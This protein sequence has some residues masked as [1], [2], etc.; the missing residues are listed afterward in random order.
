[1]DVLFRSVAGFIYKVCDIWLAD[2]KLKYAKI[3]IL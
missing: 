1:M 3:Y 2:K